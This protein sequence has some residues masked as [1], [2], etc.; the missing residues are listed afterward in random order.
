MQAL[1]DTGDLDALMERAT[2]LAA[3]WASAA[4]SA[5]TIGQEQAILRL[6][7]VAG[8]D[9]VG[10]PLA[11]EVVDRYVSP[12]PG[13]LAGGIA[14]PF[15]MAIAEYDLRP[16]ELAL[17]VAAGNV[18]LALEAELLA[19]PDR[20]AIAAA[21]AT[22]LAHAALERIDA[23]RVARRE[24]LALLGDPPRPWLGT[25][26]GEPAIVDALEEAGI[27]ID[28]GVQLIRVDVPPSRE[29]ADRLARLG[30]AVEPWEATPSSRGGLDA[31]DP[32]GQP[33]PTGSQR[34]LTVLR[35]F[36]DEAGA[37]RRGYVRLLT[38]A[39]ALSAPDQAVVAAFERI[40]IVVVDP[41][42]DIVTG[43]VDPDRKIA[44][45]VFAHRLLARAG[46]GV[47]VPAGP[48]VVAPDLATGMPSDPA[49]RSG[50][51]LALQLVAVA[52][53]R[54]NGLPAASITV[55]ALPDWLVDEPDAPA[56]AAAE[57]ALRRALLPDLGLAFMEPVLL[58]DNAV[59]WH[60]I[61][62]AILPDAG[63]VDMI[64]RRPGASLPV[65]ARLTR[66]AATVAAGLARSRVAPTLTGVAMEHAAGAVRAAEATLR[67][68]ADAGW[69]SIVDQPLGIDEARMGADAVA[70]RTESFDLLAAMEAGRGTRE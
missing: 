63:G 38:D 64:L 70:D 55:G 60:A 25:T 17:E 56:R 39:P 65:R 9:R 58:D 61:V 26:L 12:D 23:N 45:H 18:D 20:R 11:A 29:L 4:A 1:G 36:V 5:T 57:V 16:H 33:A 62:A 21:D 2:A 40:D 19:V 14:L 44:D 8:L 68:L 31:F 37:R 6:F 27:A 54:Y 24:L 42:R 43:R 13:R 67:A 46:A 50:R 41:M 7:G 35:R 59:D 28:A 3:A 49:T 66:A 53:A 22:L 52:L 30:S 32:S 51:A 10:R 34:A 48:L 47:M 15:A 69:R